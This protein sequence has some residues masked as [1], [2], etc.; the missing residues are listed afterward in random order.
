MQYARLSRTCIVTLPHAPVLFSSL[1]EDHK[2]ARFALCC[3]LFEE[4]VPDGLSV[5]WLSRIDGNDVPDRLDEEVEALRVINCDLDDFMLAVFQEVGDVAGQRS[6]WIPAR[7]DEAKPRFLR[8]TDADYAMYSAHFELFP[9]S[10]SNIGVGGSDEVTLFLQGNTITWHGLDIHAD[11]DRDITRGVAGALRERLASS[12]N[13]SYS[14]EHTPGAG[15]TTIARRIAWELRDEFP[16][17][18]V[19]R[20]VPGLTDAL[21]FVF[22]RSNLPLLCIVEA[23]LVPVAQ[24][25]LLFS[26]LKSR[27]VRFLNLDVKR[28]IRPKN[29]QHCAA[30]RDPM[31]LQEARRFLNVYSARTSKQ[32]LDNLAKL[33]SEKPE[34]R[35]HAAY[36]SPFFFGLYAFERN[37]VKVESYVKSVMDST[38]GEVRELMC[39]LALVSRYSQE[40]LPLSV[41]NVLSGLIATSDRSALESAVGEG[42][43][44]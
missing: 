24:R 44:L 22:Q 31:P 15:G 19:S 30:L 3:H 40:R 42:L 21:E 27:N 43:S 17:V 20:I 23:G 10:V 33:V 1:V 32:R 29:T 28:R 36:R 6:I 8:L 7:G 16:C 41:V 37:F 18:S 26:E 12:P 39:V 11:V 25:D 5:V 35:P 4:S 13:D 38:S 34:D 9:S 2:Q 14:I